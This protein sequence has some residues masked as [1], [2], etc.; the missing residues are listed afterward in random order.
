[1]H[2]KTINPNTITGKINTT[3]IELLSK[4][5]DG[6]RWTDLSNQIKE[7]DPNL[8]PKT[9]NGCVWL[10]AE[11]FPSKVYKPEKGLFRHTQFK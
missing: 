4:N 11:N 10:L 7:S 5:P 9:V 8:H 2:D 1:M 6:L 3:A